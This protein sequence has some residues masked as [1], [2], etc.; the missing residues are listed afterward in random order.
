MAPVVATRGSPVAFSVQASRPHHIASEC[1]EPASGTPCNLAEHTIM[2]SIFPIL[3][4]RIA[5]GNREGHTVNIRPYQAGDEFVQL[6]IYNS[7]A[8]SQTKFKAASIVDIQRRTQAKDFDPATRLYAEE[9]GA[10]VGY[11]SFQANGRV[12]YPWCLP[13]HEA[14][15]EPLLARTLQTMKERGI[16]TAFSAY[17][18]DWP[19]INDF[20]VK[21]DF[22]LA[23]EMVNFVLAFENM[24]TPSAK[25]GSSV[26]QATEADIP[27]I[28]AL[29]PKMFRVISAEA[30]KAAIWHNPWF[31]PESLFAM[32]DR[33]GAPFAAGIFITNAAYADPR[34]VDAAMPCFRLGAFGT[35]GMTTKRIKGLFSFVTRPDR[36]IFTTGMD[37]LSY[38][39][40][41]LGDDDAISCYAAQIATDAPRILAFYQRVF[42]RQG[43]FPVY[44]R[45]LTK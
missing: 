3:I 23:R 27:G 19:A 42:E 38:A 37:L 11:C 16:S 35:E 28:F 30:F 33:D 1:A 43:S 7:A 22:K 41:Q 6:K 2:L 26:T 12:G 21:H 5:F 18:K 13:D 20:F 40:Y 44:E 29:D 17:R 45:D 36:N 25:L 8:A 34:A 4:R 14:A 10:V 32:R 24:P 9:A 31:G 39:S 15:A